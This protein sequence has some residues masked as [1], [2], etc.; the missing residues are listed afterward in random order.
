MYMWA[1][2]TYITA[3]AAI[4]NFDEF[5]AQLGKVLKRR[6]EEKGLNQSDVAGPIGLRQADISRIER[7]EQG[8][9]SRTI[10]LIAR[11]LGTSLA[12][13]F[14]EVEH[15]ATLARSPAGS[16]KA[17]RTGSERLTL[18]TLREKIFEVADRALETGVPVAIERRG[19]TLLLTPRTPGAKLARLKRRKL[20][21]GSAGSLARA[22]PGTW[23]EPRNLR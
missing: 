5:R 20:V 23:R 15:A 14:A 16:Y 9:D 8:F 6:R 21:K 22:R 17:A 10:F 12:D 13:I 2:N 1:E 3:V 7:A 11:Q 19:R 18:T 4:Q